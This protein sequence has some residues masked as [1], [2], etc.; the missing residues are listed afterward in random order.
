MLKKLKRMTCRHT[1]MW[2]ERRQMDVCYRCGHA[3]AA[4]APEV[5][6]PQTPGDEGLH[7]SRGGGQA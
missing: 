4:S 7:P 3:R 6:L 2:S 1:Y 5:A